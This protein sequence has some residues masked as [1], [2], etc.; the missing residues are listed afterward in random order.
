MKQKF[1]AISVSFMKNK[2][3]TIRKFINDIHL[4]LGVGSGIT[5]FLICFSGTILVFEDEVKALFSEEITVAPTSNVLSIEEMVNSISPEGEVLRVTIDTDIYLPYK[6]SIKTNDQDRRGTTFLMNQYSGEYSKTPPNILDGFFMSMFKMHRWLML[7]I[8][9]GRPIVGISTI[10]FV[11][12]SLSGIILWFPNKKLKKL[13][14]KSIKPGLKIDFKGKWKRINHDLHVTLGFY[15]AIFLLVMS[16]T[17]LF[18]SFEWYKDAGSFVLNSEVFGN[19]GGGPKID[20]QLDDDATSISFSEV[21]K[22]TESELPFQGTTVIQIPKDKNDIFSV[23]KIH[24]Q[25]FYASATDQL[26]IDRDGSIIDKEIFS[27]KPLNYQIANSIRAIHVGSI[28]GGFSKTLYFISC[29]IATSLP[30]TGVI[31]WLNKLKKKRKK[32]RFKNNQRPI[33]N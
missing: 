16:L 19:R 15:T 13:K 26:K 22:I 20:S 18:W 14:W 4:W 7:E 17:G 33:S 10:I 11:I 5:L 23:R 24:D 9:I 3:Y 12:L 2:K 25:D 31:I 1:L 21:L 29:L 8:P 6:F 30:I 27:E 32:K 28:F